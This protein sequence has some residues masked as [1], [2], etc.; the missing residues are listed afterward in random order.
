VST[1]RTRGVAQDARASAAAI[2]GAM[3][4][5]ALTVRDGLAAG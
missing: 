3:V 1:L 5:S 4:Q 2:A